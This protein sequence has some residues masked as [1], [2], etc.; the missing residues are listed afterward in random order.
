MSATLKFRLFVWVGILLYGLSATA[1]EGPNTPIRVGII[2]LDAHAVPWTKIMTDPQTPSLIRD[3]K[4]VVAVPAVSAD[5]PFSADNIQQNT[6]AMRD[7]GVEIVDSVDDLVAKVDAVMLLSIDGRPHLAQVRPVFAA[8]KPVFIDKPVAASLADVVRIFDLARASGTPCFSSSSLRF[9]PGI[10]AMPND[11]RVGKVLGCDAYCSNA[12][13]E[14]SHP[15]LFYYGIH[16]SELLFTIMGPG[17]KTVSRVRTPTADLAAGAWE[18]GRLGTY[19]GILQGS[20]SFG[21]TVFGDQGIAPSGNFEGYEHLLVEIAKFFRT[22]QPPVTAEQT[23]EIYAFMEAADESKRQ[24][25][26]PVTLES[27]LEQARQA[28]AQP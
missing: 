27:V 17:C 4:V 25:G 1:E 11:P 22:G 12:P 23:L 8:R 9:S 26:V 14:P 2:G 7:M 10:A 18:D 21:A 16:G 19:R 24:G 3:M 13:L 28:A 5:I 15:D 6:Q 20:V